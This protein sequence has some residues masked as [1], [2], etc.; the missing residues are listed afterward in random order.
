M[1]NYKGQF[2]SIDLIFAIVIF[3]VA[4]TILAFTWSEIN[5]QLSLAYGNGATLM[6]LQA[7]TLAQVL[8]S[9]GSPANWPNFINT[10]NSLTWSNV[11][12]GLAASQGSTSMSSSKIYTFMA[13]S[14]SNYQA[15]KSLLG[16]AYDY[17][18]NIEGQSFNITI[19]S[20][21]TSG[22]ALTTY[23][24]KK[25]IFINGQPATIVVQVWT[26]EPLGVV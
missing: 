10:S 9:T 3:A 14:N 8:V 16:L 20:S 24:Q 1:K 19:G 21:P 2:W 18:I 13:M 25:N 7:Q 15:T 23:V 12:V 5:S 26:G 11:S 4:L 17:Y 6:Q 22:K